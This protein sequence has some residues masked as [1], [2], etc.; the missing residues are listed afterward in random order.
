MNGG[1]GPLNAR[2]K[3]PP[4]PPPKPVQQANATTTAPKAA[5]TATALQ[6]DVN[7]VQNRVAEAAAAP[8]HLPWEQSPHMAPALK[9]TFR[10]LG[11]EALEALRA[12]DWKFPDIRPYFEETCVA[13]TFQQQ[14]A[15][16][17]P[18]QYAETRDKLMNEDP[19]VL[20]VPNPDAYDPPIE[21]VELNENDVKFLEEQAAQAEPPLSDEQKAEMY[22]Q[23]A[24]MKVAA[25]NGGHADAAPDAIAE[26]AT[27]A[28][29]GTTDVDGRNAAGLDDDQ[30]SKFTDA[31]MP[32]EED[33]HAHRGVLQNNPDK[34]RGII[35]ERAAEPGGVT[36]TVDNGEGNGHAVIV[37]S[38]GKGGYYVRDSEGSYPNG[39]RAADYPQPMSEDQLFELLALDQDLGDSGGRGGN[40][41]SGG[42]VIVY[43]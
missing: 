42:T 7:T 38:D 20:H 37:E 26:G 33:N 39:D 21:Q 13:A 12:K 40:K 3:L 28:T 34:A 29:D 19:H 35:A 15:E 9:L 8:S 17:N 25:V 31:F 36:V 32:G 27:D 5:A 23:Y 11:R 1:T 2:I 30:M 4:P 18:E 22:M 6:S 10:N 16:T 24:L 14:W 41:G 43:E